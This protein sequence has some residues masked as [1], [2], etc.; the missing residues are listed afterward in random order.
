MDEFAEVK[1]FRNRF[2]AGMAEALLK[3]QGLN[4]L[5]QSDDCGGIRPDLAFTRGIRILV[6]KIDLS[7]AQEI[8]EVLKKDN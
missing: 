4:V 8:L 1:S 3:E 2:E 7:R 6:R 5:V